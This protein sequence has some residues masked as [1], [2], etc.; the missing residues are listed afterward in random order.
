MHKISLLKWSI[1]FSV[2]FFVLQ[3]CAGKKETLKT[4]EGNPEILYKQGLVLF[5]K[6]QYTEAL[7]KFQQLKSSFPDS[8]PHTLWA[9]M[10]VGDCHFFKQEYVEALAAYEEFKKIHPTHEEIIYV[11]YQIGMSYFSQMRTLDRDQT[12]TRKALSNFEYLIANY[13]SSLFTYKAKEKMDVCRKRLAD[14]EFYIGNFYYKD[15]KFQAA[16]SRFE[17]LLAKFP[18][19]PDEDKTLFFLGKAYLELGRGEKVREA[20]ARIIN[21][22]PKSPHYKEAKA[23]L[24]HGLQKKT[25]LPKTK[26]EGSLETST[27]IALI[28]FE[29]EGRIPLSSSSVPIM[30]AT[31]KPASSGEGT[32]RIAPSTAP[33][34]EGRTQASRQSSP[35]IQSAEPTSLPVSPAQESRI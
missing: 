9:E 18:K 20:L 23:I 17:G 5:N 31:A 2:I 33:A 14:H 11:Q 15:N 21:E 29:E 4:I 30:K 24:D 7:T 16:A 32:E 28:K 10:K 35:P 3:G 12:S 27:E 6:G 25:P 13:P 8:P 19:T 22:Y 34:Q 1:L 26:K